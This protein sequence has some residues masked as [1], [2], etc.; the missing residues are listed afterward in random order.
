MYIIMFHLLPPPL[1]SGFFWCHGCVRY[2]DTDYTGWG[3]RRF[4]LRVTGTNQSEGRRQWEARQPATETRT[5][6]KDVEEMGDVEMNMV[7][8]NFKHVGI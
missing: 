1:G 3:L 8:N 7:L 5:V 2:S 4:G 6:K